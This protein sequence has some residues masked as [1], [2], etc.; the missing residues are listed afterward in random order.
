[1]NFIAAHLILVRVFE[2]SFWILT[3]IVEQML[4]DGFYLAGLGDLL[5]NIDTFTELVARLPLLQKNWTP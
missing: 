5:K 4:G 1:M 2:T 3:G